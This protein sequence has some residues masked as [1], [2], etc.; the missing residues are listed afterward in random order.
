MGALLVAISVS[1]SVVYL[2]QPILTRSQRTMDY[3][4]NYD[5]LTAAPLKLRLLC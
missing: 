2:L 5:S 4:R 1:D 3:R